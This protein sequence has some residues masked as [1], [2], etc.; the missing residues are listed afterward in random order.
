[1]KLLTLT[2][3]VLA[4]LLFIGC[5][6]GSSDEYAYSES[7][8]D[9]YKLTK[10]DTTQSY[11]FYGEV[12]FKS[13]GSLKNVSVIKA[14]DPTK[15]ITTATMASDIS[16]PVIST[17]LEYNQTDQSYKNLYAGVLS[18]VTDSGEAYRVDM[19]S[20]EAKK[21]TK[22]GKLSDTDYEKIDYLGSKWYLLAH[23]DDANKTVLISPDMSSEADAIEFGDRK[24]LS[25]TY[26]SYG[27]DAD[28]YLVYN[29]Q[30]S[31]V[32]K[33]SLSMSCVDVDFGVEVGSRDFEGDIQASTYSLFIIDDKLYKLDKNSLMVESISLGDKKIASG[34]G[35]TDMQGGS[36]Y[37][38]GEDSNL[39]RVALLEN[40]IVK[41]TPT[42]DERVE[43]IRGFTD[44]YVIYGSDTLLMAAKKDG[45]TKEPKLLA[46][47]TKTSGYKYVKDYGIGQNYL[48]VTYD[49]DTKTNDTR[50]KACIFNSGNIEC[51]N[52]SFWAGATIKKDG[53]RDFESTF[54]YTPY[55]YIRVDD[56][57]NFGG[58]VLKAIDPNHP[59]DDGIAM[60]KVDKYNFQTFLTNS[61][62]REETID[63]DGGVVFFAKNDE[64]FHIDAFYFNL[65]KEN[66]L[67]QLTNSDPFPDVISG[68][69]HCHGRVCM[70]CHNLAGGKI[71]QDLRGSKSA[72]GY[73]I[74]IEFEDKTTFLADIAKGKGENFSIPLK[75]LTNN[76]KAL[77]VDQN[78]EVVNSSAGY[79]HEGVSSANCNFCHGRY[80]A[81]RYDAPGAIT[82]Q[83]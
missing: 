65:L 24:L 73:R 14:D 11:L 33:C 21:Y 27:A 47:T 41:V 62:Y 19:R 48:F 75:K 50:Y 30:T 39:Y 28:G 25:L 35:T 51:K 74:K 49:I 79:Y 16:Y 34:H 36:F 9:I 22:V 31:K 55:A 78:G 17:S 61:R 37:F 68:R 57:D 26:P 70:I 20:G 12:N 2:S 77:V 60:G 66:S 3:T 81:T 7:S 72:Y 38:I 43:R 58:G 44:D 6:G 45:S 80:G 82:I 52:D 40:E 18:Y 54:T 4:S 76:F 15:A 8:S 5:G 32:Q 42:P 67:V 63:S 71:Y 59:F 1:M 56:T 10:Q 64:T 83:R 46:E 23:D 69:D 53:K 13:L 29:N